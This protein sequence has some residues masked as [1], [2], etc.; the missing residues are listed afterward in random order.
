MGKT[1]MALNI[2]VHMA[3]QEKVP[4]GIFSL[5][6]SNDQL[7]MRLLCGE[8]HVSFHGIRTGYMSDTDYQKLAVAVQYLSK[9]PIYTDDSPSLTTM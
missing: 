2:A 3:V 7:A 4:V 6:M 8:S 5:E 1:A 9:A